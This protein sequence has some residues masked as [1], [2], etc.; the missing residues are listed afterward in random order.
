MQHTRKRR[1]GSWSVL[2]FGAIFFANGLALAQ[3]RNASI[4]GTITDNSGAAEPGVTITVTS[5]A[6]QV[7]EL[8]KVSEADGSY[9]FLELPVGTYRLTYELSG[10]SRLAREDIRLTT[11]FV[12]RVDVTL[13]VA[14]IAETVTVSG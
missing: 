7:P 8:V 11:G 4:G 3:S 13:S 5:P 6:L 10:F 12:A 9:Q 2:A 14:T 1:W